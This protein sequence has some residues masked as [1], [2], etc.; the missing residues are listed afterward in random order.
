MTEQEFA[1]TRLATFTPQQLAAVMAV[2]GATLLLAVPGSGKTT[3]LIHRLGYM[4]HV[5]GINP[6]SILTV[7]YTV[8]ATEEMKARFAAKFGHEYA[9]RMEFRTINGICQKIIHYYCA[10]YGKR[11]H[12]LIAE[13]EQAKLVNGLYQQI[14]GEYPTVSD[15]KNVQSAITYIK[16]MRLSD[17]QIDAFKS[18]LP[19][20]AELYRAYCAELRRRNLMDYD[21]QMRYALA[22]L[23]K[24]PPV[25]A[26]FQDQF[27]YLCVDESQDT[28][29]IQHDII[30][31][32]ASKYGHLF[33][34]LRRYDP[35]QGG[36]V[37]VH[38]RTSLFRIHCRGYAEP[39]S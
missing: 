39:S 26:H 34:V 29:K 5:C 17:E 35:F 12:E 36:V 2:E 33:M 10:T 32:L 19:K 18:D 7:T 3:V 16:N 31:L 6:A 15:V 37:S 38:L 30:K 21:D 28:S 24:C 23:E 9:D 27:R 20:I 1:K 11:A 25:L 14:V 22:F 8:A 4:V 13:S